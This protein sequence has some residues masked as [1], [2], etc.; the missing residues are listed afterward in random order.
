M[1]AKPRTANICKLCIN[2][3]LRHRL[4][5][6]F[7]HDPRLQ[8]PSWAFLKIPRPLSQCL[9][10]RHR[11]FTTRRFPAVV[12]VST[13][14]PKQR[15][16][17]IISPGDLTHSLFRYRVMMMRSQQRQEFM[18]L[19]AAVHG[20]NAVRRDSRLVPAG[21]GDLHRRVPFCPSSRCSN[22]W[23]P[24]SQERLLVSGKDRRRC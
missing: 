20:P 18:P 10:H 8:F 7:F 11:F 16:M 24:D 6:G 23:E 9:H 21:E 17:P 19:P 15:K 13:L 12:P 5:K 3:Q 22:A 14:M 2:K 1:L 4:S